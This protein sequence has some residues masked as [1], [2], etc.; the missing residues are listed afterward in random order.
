MLFKMI[1]V[2]SPTS[3]FVSQKNITQTVQT[4]FEKV[5]KGIQAQQLLNIRISLV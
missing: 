2:H 3:G 4:C 5:A 1:T